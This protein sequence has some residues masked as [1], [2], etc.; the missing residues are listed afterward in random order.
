MEESLVRTERLKV[1]DFLEAYLFSKSITAIDSSRE[2]F[3][4]LK[5]L[6]CYEDWNELAEFYNQPFRQELISFMFDGWE[7][8]FDEVENESLWVLEE[9]QTSI[10]FCENLYFLRRGIDDKQKTFVLSNPSTLDYFIRDCKRCKI[11]L[12]WKEA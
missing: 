6:L 7:Y 11:N 5:E 8:T 10:T 12:W 2:Y 9:Q 1:L 4:E 3:R